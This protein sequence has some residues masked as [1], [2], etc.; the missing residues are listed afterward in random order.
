MKSENFH[1]AE[2]TKNFVSVSAYSQYL[3]QISKTEIICGEML[4]L[5]F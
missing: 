2:V 3:S 5:I 4:Q 1:C